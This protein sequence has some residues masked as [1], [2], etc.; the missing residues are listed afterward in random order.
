[1]NKIIDLEDMSNLQRFEVLQQ[2][3]NEIIEWINKHEN[4]FKYECNDKGFK[5]TMREKKE[6]KQE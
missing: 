2:S 3:I 1:M 5:I 4:D 6:N